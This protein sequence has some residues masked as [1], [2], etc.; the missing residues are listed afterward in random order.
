MTGTLTT[1]S[2]S[3]ILLLKPGQSLTIALTVAS[4]EEFVGRVAV[5]RQV[6]NAAWQTVRD[7]AGV[8]QEFVG[9]EA[10]PLT[11]GTI[12]DTTYVNDTHEHQRLS[13]GVLELGDGSD[14]VS[15]AVAPPAADPIVLSGNPLTLTS[16]LFITGLPTED[17]VVAGQV[18]LSSGA[19][20][21]SAGA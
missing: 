5:Q 16:P 17:P 6:G 9:T 7:P 19:L 20:K 2:R 21:V 13:V 4:L 3:P 8:V 18:Y 14:G 11:A 1:A 12:S 10:V 15:Y